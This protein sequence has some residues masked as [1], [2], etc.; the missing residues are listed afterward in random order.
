MMGHRTRSKVCPGFSSVMQY[1]LAHHEGLSL[2]NLQVR[3][4]ADAF[5]SNPL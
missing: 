1:W 4:C 2:S 3:R 5:V